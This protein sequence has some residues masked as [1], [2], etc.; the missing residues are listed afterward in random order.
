MRRFRVP[1][2]AYGKHGPA[3]SNFVFLSLSVPLQWDQ[4]NQQDREVAARLAMVEQLRAERGDATRGH[5]A[6]TLT[7][8]QEWHNNRQRL[9]RYDATKVPLVAERTRAANADYRGGGSTLMP[10][11][12]ARRAEIDTRVEQLRLAMETDRLWTRLTYLIPAGHNVA[13]RP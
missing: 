8:L 11:L 1:R 12:E 6:E 5:V 2:C 3:Y 9:G 4:K 10:L 7:L 13:A